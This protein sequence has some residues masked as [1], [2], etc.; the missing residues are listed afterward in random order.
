MDKIIV[1]GAGIAG[2]SAAYHAKHAGFDVTCFEKSS[3]AG[4]LIS[5]FSVQGFRFDKAIHLSFTSSEYVRSVFDKTEYITHKPNS[6]CI[7]NKKWFKHP[8]QN[9]LFPLDTREK[10]DLITS[11]I[12]RPELNP[13]NYGEWLDHQYGYEI[14]KRYPRPYTIKYWSLEAEKLSTTWIGNRVRRA[15]VK[16]VLLGAFEK[17]DDNHYYAS[18]MRYP[19]VGGYYQFIKDIADSCDIETGKEAVEIDTV[20]KCVVFS[21]GDRKKYDSLI[22]TIPLPRIIKLIPNV[23]KNVRVAA[24][25]LLWTTVDLISVGFNKENVPPY[26]WF[27]IYDEENI[28]ARAYSPSLKSKDNAPPGKSSLQ[29]EIYNLS[30]KE[31]LEPEKL[32]KNIQKKLLEMNICKEEDIIFMHHKHLPFG[33]VVFDHGMEERRQVVLDYL[34]AQDIRSC[35]RFGEWD[36]LWSDQSFLSG[37]NVILGMSKYAK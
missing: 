28:A 6:Y 21:D 31:R 14:S 22:S 7:E 9:N 13:K 15:D 19:K 20:K 26:L 30:T 37:Q 18:E 3:K 24:E 8:I 27:Y 12:S 11:F 5:N 33:N 29:F 36:Y 34:A 1:L 23:P 35:G 4:G 32:I 17:R 2:I 10:V 25:S 16:E